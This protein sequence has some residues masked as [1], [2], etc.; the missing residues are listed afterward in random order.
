MP[1]PLLTLMP[2]APTRGRP[3]KSA[4]ILWDVDDLLKEQ[5]AARV[6]PVLTAL[7]ERD[8]LVQ[9]VLSGDNGPGVFA[10]ADRFGLAEVLDF[11]VGAYGLDSRV[12]AR[13]V[14]AAQRRAERKYAADFTRRNTI[15]V[16]GTPGDVRA[17]LGGGAKVIGVAA[18]RAAAEA[19]E[20]EGAD[21]VLPVQAGTGGFLAAVGTLLA[22][23]AR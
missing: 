16:G 11:Q 21:I 20:W 4:L 6:R 13:L 14:A 23:P 8:E 5:T 22:F 10:K 3:V 17:G 12:R 7:A 19:L 9:T 1:S 2:S 15:L 18:D